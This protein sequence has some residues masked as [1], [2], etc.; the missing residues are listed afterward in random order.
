MFT[1]VDTERRPEASLF[2]SISFCCSFANDNVLLPGSCVDVS[3]LYSD[4]GL[5]F[6]GWLIH[7][8]SRQFSKAFTLGALI[9]CSVKEFHTFT[10]LEV[11][12]FLRNSYLLLCFA[13]FNEC[14]RVRER[15]IT[16]NNSEVTRL[17]Y[18]S[19]KILYTSVMSPLNLR[20]LN[21]GSSNFCSLSSICSLNL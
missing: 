21:V 16:F 4:S 10:T 9:T 20:N 13:N 19:C 2:S 3:G 11:K 12:K 14:P 18:T 5:Y 17:S 15:P 7:S 8:L 6:I 1:Y